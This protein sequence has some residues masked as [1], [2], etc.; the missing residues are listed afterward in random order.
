MYDEFIVGELKNK[1][2]KEQFKDEKLDIFLHGH[3]HQKSLA[4]VEPSRIM[5]S[6]P[7][8]YQVTV[9]PWV[10]V[11]WQARTV[12]RK[13]YEMSMKIGEEILF[14]TI[15]NTSEQL[16]FQAPGTS[17][18]QQIK[19]A[20]GREALHPIVILNRALKIKNH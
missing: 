6:I 8:N 18:R 16:L 1:I 2:R 15:R 11:E 13:H 12:M 7:E 17:C 5:L 14:P 20:T 3:C 19:H 4:S 9:I 10:V